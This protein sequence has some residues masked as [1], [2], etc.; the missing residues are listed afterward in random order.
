MNIPTLIASAPTE[1]LLGLVI[2]LAVA[3]LILFVLSTEDR[4]RQPVADFTRRL[5]GRRRWLF[6]PGAVQSLAQGDRHD[7]AV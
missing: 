3:G 5:R 1:N 2:L 6:I 4:H 7:Y